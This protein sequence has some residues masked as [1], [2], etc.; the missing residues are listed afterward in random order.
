MLFHGFG[1]LICNPGLDAFFDKS[2]ISAQ[3]I[4]LRS[5]Q[6]IQGRIWG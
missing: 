5:W 3:G 6:N 2:E 4:G 1:T